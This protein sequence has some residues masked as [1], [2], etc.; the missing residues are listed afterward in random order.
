MD[1]SISTIFGNFEISS[2]PPN[3][4]GA[5]ETLQNGQKSFFYEDF[6]EL[7][8]SAIL[9]VSNF[10]SSQNLQ[11]RRFLSWAK[12]RHSPKPLLMQTYFKGSRRRF[13]RFLDVTQLAGDVQISHNMFK[14][15]TSR[16][17][18]VK[19]CSDP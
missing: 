15:L 13:S 11:N 12:F 6:E 8:I 5:F 4:S 14:F 1:S 2:Y 16:I 18:D 10:F 19:D 7:K 9:Y 17:L 3:L